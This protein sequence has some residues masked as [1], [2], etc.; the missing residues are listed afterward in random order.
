MSKFPAETHRPVKH[1]PDLPG[2]AAVVPR[3]DEMACEFDIVG[4]TRNE[5]MLQHIEA[6][7]LGC[8]GSSS[9]EN[10]WSDSVG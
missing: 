3:M 7:T 8:G 10:T 4:K 9:C 1:A 6:S 5:D 2:T